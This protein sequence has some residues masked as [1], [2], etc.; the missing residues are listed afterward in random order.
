MFEIKK[1][2]SIEA[3]KKSLGSQAINA[4]ATWAFVIW[5]CICFGC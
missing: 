4:A 5:T 2:E 3:P 1:V